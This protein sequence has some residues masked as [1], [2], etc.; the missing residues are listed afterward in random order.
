MVVTADTAGRRADRIESLLSA[1]LFVEPQLTGDRLTFASNL[2]GHLSLF[3]MDAS[4]GVP[5]PLLP[6]QIALQNPELVG[7][8]LFHVLPR[9]EQIV[10]MLDSDG[11]ENYVPYV[12]P[13]EGGFPEPLRRVER[14]REVAHISSRSTTT[15]RSRTSP[16]SRARS[17]SIAAVRVRA[18][19]R[20][21]R[22]ARR[23]PVRRLR[24]RVDAATTRA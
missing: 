21:G 15:P 11:D 19:D 17:R 9:L 22:D 12:V 20:R 4:G 1:R 5:E 6:P 3:A 13:L 2:A 16:S 10:V 23:E 8:H 18:R 24:R 7:G 14:S